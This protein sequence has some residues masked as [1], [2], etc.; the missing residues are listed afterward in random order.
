MIAG[1]VKVRVATVS[2]VV[3]AAF[4]MVEAVVVFLIDM[5]VLVSVS[6]VKAANN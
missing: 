1:V 2:V 5:L 3:T 4:V 6:P